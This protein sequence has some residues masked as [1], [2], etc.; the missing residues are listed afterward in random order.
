MPSKNL[1]RFAEDRYIKTL[2]GLQHVHTLVIN[3]QS[4]EEEE[5]PRIKYHRDVSSLR[6]A[7][8]AG[9]GLCRL[10]EGQADAILAEIDGL[11]DAQRE[12]D[13]ALPNFDMWLT[14]R[15]DGGEGFWVLSECEGESETPVALPIA[16]IAFVASEGEFQFV[17][18]AA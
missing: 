18:P 7:A 15:P 10:I 2:T 4:C 12:L 13:G 17:L 6:R 1:P 14:K 3:R 16:A 5:E 8:A 11:D 9:C